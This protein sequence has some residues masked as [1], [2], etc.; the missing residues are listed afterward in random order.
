LFHLLLEVLDLGL[1]GLELASQLG[2]YFFLGFFLSCFAL[3]LFGCCVAG[4]RDLFV[5]EEVARLADA[6]STGAFLE[7]SFWLETVLQG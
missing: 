6:C 3:L 4:C 1:G 2:D 5:R 7:N